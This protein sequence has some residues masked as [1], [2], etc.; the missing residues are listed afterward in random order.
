M[1]YCIQIVHHKH[2]WERVPNHKHANVNHLQLHLVH[3][4][5]TN[6]SRVLKQ[7]ELSNALEEH[8]ATCVCMH[9]HPSVH[10]VRQKHDDGAWLCE[11]KPPKLWITEVF[12]E[13]I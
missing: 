5:R 11:T 10:H 1:I 13:R 9:T 4:T 12:S 3:E 7:E 8:T 2:R 6:D